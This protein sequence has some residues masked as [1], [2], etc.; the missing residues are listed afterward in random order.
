M[1]EFF[2][3]PKF[4]SLSDFTLL[5]LFIDIYHSSEKLWWFSYPLKL[6]L[7]YINFLYNLYFAIVANKPYMVIDLIL[8]LFTITVVVYLLSKRSGLYKILFYFSHS[9]FVCVVVFLCHH[10]IRY[11]QKQRVLTFFH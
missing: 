2:V 8:K 5:K 7:H 1:L 4:F 9:T 10:I 6:E 3:L 11:L